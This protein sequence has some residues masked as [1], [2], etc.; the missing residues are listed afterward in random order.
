MYSDC[1]RAALHVR[2]ADEACHIGPARPRESY[3]RI[4]ALLDAARRTGADA[5][6][7][8]TASWRRTP[9]FARACRDAGLTSSDLLPKPSPRWAARPPR[10]RRRSRRRAVV[11]GTDEPLGSGDDAEVARI[12]DGRLS[13]HGQGGVRRR[14]QGDAHGRSS[15]RRWPRGPDRTIRGEL[16]IRRFCR[17]SR[18]PYRRPRHIEIQLLGD[19]HGTDHSVCRTGVFDPAAPSEGGRRITVARRVPGA[20]PADGRGRGGRRPRGRVTPAPARL[21]FFSTRAETFFLPRDEHPAAGRA[22]RHRDGDQ[23][24][25]GAMADQDCTRREDRHRS[26]TRVDSGR[27]CDRMPDLRRGSGRGVHAVARLDSRAPASRRPWCAR[28][29][30]GQRRVCRADV[31]RFDD[32]EAD[33]MGADAGRGDRPDEPRAAASTRCS[34]YARRSRS[35]HGSCTSPSTPPGI[36]TRRIWIELLADRAQATEGAART[37]FNEISVH[38]EEVIAIGAALDAYIRASAAPTG[39]PANGRAAWVETAR[40]EALRG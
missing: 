10:G 40:R 8:D 14:R 22:S 27:P 7:P 23:H 20:A 38:D 19:T 4:E 24:R 12:A 2:E 33:R 35:F 9:A 11:P 37:S 31:L 25:P 13:P 5:S 39:Q 28:R 1:D 36:T 17:L 16:G 18:A 6:I 26:R 29:W 34:G 21:N 32:C 30:R 15:R 3:L